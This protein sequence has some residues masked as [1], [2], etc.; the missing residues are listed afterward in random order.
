MKKKL[1][2]FLCFM[3][4][5]TSIVGC[6]RSGEVTDVDS[7]TD[8][9]VEVDA[10]ESEVEFVFSQA[11]D[12][13]GF[14]PKLMNFAYDMTMVLHTH[15]PLVRMDY[16]GNLH[17]ALAESWDISDD[18]LEYTFYLRED[19]RFQDGTPLTASDVKF[20]WDRARET[21][22]SNRFTYFMDEVEVIND[23]EVKL[24]LKNPVAGVLNYLSMAN[25]C[26]VSEK[27]VNEIG[28]DEY[29]F[30]PVGTGPFKLDEWEPGGTVYL[31]ANEDYYLGAPKLDKLTVKS[32]KESTTSVIALEKGEVDAVM[33]V[34]QIN[35][36]NIMDNDKLVWAEEAGTTYWAIFF[37]TQLPPFDNPLLRR[38]IYKAIEPQEIVN[39]ALNGQGEVTDIAL[40]PKTNGYVPDIKRHEYNIEEAKELLAQAGFPDGLS[41]T[42]YCRQ[43]W[44]Q[45]AGQVIQQQLAK[46]NIDLE[47]VVMETAALTADRNKGLLNMFF[48]GN[49]DLI[50]DAELPLSYLLSSGIGS[51]NHTR[52]SNEEYDRLYEELVNTRDKDKRQEIIK[53]LLLIEV[54]ETPR[55]PIYFPINN[56]VYNKEFVNVRPSVT[57]IHYFYDVYKAQ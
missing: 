17:P 30:N 12:V 49:G 37:N 57:S 36:Q 26:I 35:K 52:F 45:K 33:G 29:R 55:V 4:L 2:M 32:I 38:A 39:I 19:V 43:D 56:I 42:L 6:N 20:S 25:N 34:P 1:C 14:D 40:H 10:T 11:Q 46:I 16:D 22:E 53:R 28:E 51:S 27:I 7:K 44:Q 31:S 15:D 13:T 50:L 3:I 8:G 18:G 41:T 48:V 5:I 47:L 54:E 23:Y 21:P 24:K 9:E